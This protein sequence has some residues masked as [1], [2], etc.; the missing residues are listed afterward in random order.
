MKKT[1]TTIEVTDSEIKLLQVQKGRGIYTII[2]SD[3]QPVISSSEE[4]LA[5]CLRRM[6]A[7][8]PVDSDE[9]ILLVPRRLVILRQ[10][11]FPSD[12]YEEIQDMI[13]LQLI[14]N[15]PYPVEDI[16]YQH[17]MLEKDGKGKSRVLAIIILKEVSQRY[18]RLL[19]QVGI[20]DGRLTLS[21]F[22][23]QQW[24]VYQEKVHKVH[25]SQPTMMINIDT[26][27]CEICFC[28]NKNLYF[29][30][31]I[32]YGREYLALGESKE[33]IDQIKLSLE[34]YQKEQLG[35]V[36][37]KI[38][39]L[40][41]HNEGEV[42]KECINREM[43]ITVKVLKPL[44][45]IS[46]LSSSQ[47]AV[48]RLEKPCSLTAGLGLIL[49][50][51]SNVINLAPVEI[52]EEK[53]KREQRQKLV[54]F[55]CLLLIAAVLSVFGQF[56]DMHKNKT[57]LKSLKS[58]L[59]NL[60]PQL[61]A[62]REKIQ[63]VQLYDQKLK[64][65]NFIPDVID[66]L[67]RVTPQGIT[68]RTLSLRRDGNLIIQGYAKTNAGINDFQSRLIRSPGFH[69]VDLKFATKRRVANMPVMDFKIASQLGSGEEV[70][71][72]SV[73]NGR[74]SAASPTKISDFGEAGEESAL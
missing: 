39:I 65:S 45:G 40:S 4:D 1:V 24:L 12:H 30:R 52:H 21:S 68:F 50:N 26:Q 44:Y 49:S 38:L 31:T 33:L 7:L 16:M 48:L 55:V 14:N 56:I 67:N 63:F 10:M 64:R 11:T 43:D 34:A 5:D 27:H 3:V 8:L 74:D 66:R 13:G 69:N 60:Q 37:T 28:H 15:I 51:T 32:P 6:V 70:R 59:A 54:K 36:L 42:L 53:Q 23:I 62:A 57:T 17:H 58:E 18:C 19:Q 72:I 25:N 2:F 47:S 35:P 73:G 22:G 41:A 29:S 9:F 61:Q 71:R 46:G 20:K